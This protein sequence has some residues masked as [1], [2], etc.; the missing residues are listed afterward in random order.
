MMKGEHQMKKKTLWLVLAVAL[1]AAGCG[2]YGSNYN[3]TTNPPP[4][5]NVTIS[6]LSPASATAGGSGFT[7]T[8]N[9]SGFGAG[10]V[11]YFNGNTRSTTYITTGQIMASIPA[12]DIAS[13]GDKPVY[14]RTGGNN[15]NT[16]QF[17]V[18]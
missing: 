2:G 5:G 1:T 6:G 8:V 14:V 15:S 18:K 17:N 4:S 7:L 13:A 10:A 9:G 3:S 16:M 12:S 11:V